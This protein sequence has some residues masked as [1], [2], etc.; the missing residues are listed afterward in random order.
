MKKT[1]TILSLF[2][3]NQY[4]AQVAIGKDSISNSSV[5][6]EFS[7][8]SRGLILPWITSAASAIG[9]VD[10]TFIYDVSDKK[11]KYRQAGTWK[12][13]SIDTT[14]TVNTVLQNSKTELAGAKIV[15]GGNGNTDTTAGI[16]VLADQDKAMILPKMDT[17]HLNIINPAAGMMAYDTATHQLAVFNGTVWT[18]WKP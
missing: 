17:P 5:S 1:I 10:G 11:V 4:F 13:L 9:A 3:L 12:D 18:F 16:L 14:G 2:L 15:I 7:N 6:L 8:G